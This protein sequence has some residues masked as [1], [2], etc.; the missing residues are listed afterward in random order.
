MSY[1][2]VLLPNR[3]R[4]SDSGDSTAYIIKF[5]DTIASLMSRH[6]CSLVYEFFREI[7]SFLAR[8]ANGNVYLSCDEPGNPT[9]GFPS[10]KEKWLP[11]LIKVH[12]SKLHAKFTAV[13]YLVVIISS[14]KT[15]VSSYLCMALTP[16]ASIVYTVI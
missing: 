11:P 14:S 1:W 15:L 16:V 10:G 8:Y 9:S 3:I 5:F 12:V 4:G 2:E 6:L 13:G 7:G